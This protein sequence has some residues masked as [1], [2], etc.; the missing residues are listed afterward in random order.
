MD[1]VSAPC[2]IAM[3]TGFISM[4]TLHVLWLPY[5]FYGYL[6]SLITAYMICIPIT[7]ASSY[8]TYYLTSM[9]P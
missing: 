8:F 4:D 1:T 5:M 9:I 2:F 6:T 3:D 7:Y